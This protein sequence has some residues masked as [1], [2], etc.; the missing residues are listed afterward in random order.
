MLYNFFFYFLSTGIV[1]GFE[2]EVYSV[3]EAT[4]IVRVCAEIKS[5]SLG[6]NAAVRLQTSDGSATSIFY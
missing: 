2:M 5:G 6:R 3:T 4:S 1:I